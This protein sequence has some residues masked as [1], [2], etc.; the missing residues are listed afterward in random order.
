[1][2]EQGTIQDIAKA[3]KAAGPYPLAAYQFVQDGL[4][5]TVERVHDHADSVGGS[6]HVS[7]QQLCMG[8]RDFAIDQFG[9]LAPVVLASWH[10]HRTDD[11]GRMVFAL[12]EVGAMS[13]T[14]Q[15]TM[16]D[17]RGVYE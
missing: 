3:L 16:D 11:F 15:D 2:S 17:F 9:F 1:M 10:V 6:R 4:R 14:S 13:K 7:G 8:L 5:A 12:I